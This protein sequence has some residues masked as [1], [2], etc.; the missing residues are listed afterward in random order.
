MYMAMREIEKY[1]KMTYE[2]SYDRIILLYI[3]LSNYI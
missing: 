3:N 2:L 1:F